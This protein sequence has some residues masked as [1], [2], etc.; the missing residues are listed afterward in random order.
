MYESLKKVY[1]LPDET[2]VFVGHD[3]MPGGREPRW[4]TT[5]AKSKANNPQM[6]ANTTKEEFVKFRT[7]RDATLAAPRLL[8]QSVQVNIDAGKLPEA[9]DNDIAYLK[10]PLN[11]FRGAEQAGVEDPFSVTLVEEEIQV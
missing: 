10:I 3:Y 7:E 1:A 2:R 6:K 5:I 11:V 8:F 9:E 4:E